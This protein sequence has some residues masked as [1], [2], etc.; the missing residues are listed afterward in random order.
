MSTRTSAADSNYLSISVNIPY[1]TI[2]QQVPIPAPPV[3]TPD[4]PGAFDAI[5][6]VC[7]GTTGVYLL[8]LVVSQGMENAIDCNNGAN[9]CA[10][11]G[12]IGVPTGAALPTLPD[13]CITVK[14]AC[15]DLLFKGTLHSRGRIAECVIGAWSD[16]SH[17]SAY[18]LDFSQLIHSDGQ[19]IR[20]VFGR[21]KHPLLALIGHAPDISLPRGANVLFWRSLGEMAYWW[22]KWVLV[23]VGIL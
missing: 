5:V 16:Q 14:G 13:Q 9:H 3:F 17:D 7:D 11:D 4:N 12:D 2:G 1:Y 23:K 10:F 21:V 22:G 18:S 15:H 6:K 19:P 8:G 20:F